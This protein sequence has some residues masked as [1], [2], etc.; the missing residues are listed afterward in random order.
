MDGINA[1]GTQNILILTTLEK[2]K[3]KTLNFL[4]DV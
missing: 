3:E 1:D 4:K 2:T